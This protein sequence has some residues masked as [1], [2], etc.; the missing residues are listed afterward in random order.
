MWTWEAC[1]CQRPISLQ[2][3]SMWLKS[4]AGLWRN[5]LWRSMSPQHREQHLTPAALASRVS[6]SSTSFL[7]G[8]HIFSEEYFLLCC[9]QWNFIWHK[10]ICLLFSTWCIV[11]VTRVSYDLHFCYRPEAAGSYLHQ[12][13]ALS[14]HNH[15]HWAASHTAAMV[16][17]KQCGKEEHGKASIIHFSLVI[18]HTCVY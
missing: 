4:T 3:V 10:I 18:K 11:L 7:D 9:S 15:L 13:Q 16:E 17:A 1:L 12:Q 2:L 5:S 14:I 6:K 8:G